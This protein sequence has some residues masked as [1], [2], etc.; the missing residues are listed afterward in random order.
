MSQTQEKAPGYESKGLI[1]LASNSLAEATDSQPP[2]CDC[3]SPDDWLCSTCRA[4]VLPLLAAEISRELVT[5]ISFID[6]K[7]ARERDAR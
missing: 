2:K 5:T 4:A 1:N 3:S 7:L 6:V